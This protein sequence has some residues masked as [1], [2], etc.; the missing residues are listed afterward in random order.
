[1]QGVPIEK[2]RLECNM[3][4]IRSYFEILSE[5]ITGVPAG[6]VFNLDESGFQDWEDRRERMVIT[7]SIYGA[8]SIEISVDR[9]TKGSSLF[10]HRR[11]WHMA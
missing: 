5:N 7:P 4:E 10:V 11:G 8:D 3:S 2:K 1:M 9:D 6:F